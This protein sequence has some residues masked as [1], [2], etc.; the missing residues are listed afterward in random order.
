MLPGLDGLDGET[1]G[2]TVLDNRLVQGDIGQ[3]ELMAE[4]NVLGQ[5]GGGLLALQG[6]GHCISFF[7][8]LE[9]GGNIVL[10]VD[11]DCLGF[12]FY[13][14]SSLSSVAS[15]PSVDSR[16]RDDECEGVSRLGKCIV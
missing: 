13:H 10:C 14:T 2:F 6:D 15:T 9:G 16:C 3:C 1:D 4:R 7:E 11:E 12:H 8:V 5:R